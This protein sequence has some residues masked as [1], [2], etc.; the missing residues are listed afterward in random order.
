MAGTVNLSTGG[1]DVS[2]DSAYTTLQTY[3]ES[4]DTTLAQASEKAKSGNTVD[5]MNLEMAIQ[6]WSLSTDLESET[7][8]AVANAIRSIIRN[9]STE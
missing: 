5:T 1:G 3:V 7:I 2:V 4:Q 8:K 6:R 9:V